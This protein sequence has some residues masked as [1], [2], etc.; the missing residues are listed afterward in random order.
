MKYEPPEPINL[1]YPEQRG[2][3]LV[4]RYFETSPVAYENWGP[5]GDAM[6]DLTQ[7]LMVRSAI[8]QIRLDLFADLCYADAGYTSPQ[9][10]F[11]SRGICGKAIFRHPDFYPHLQFFI[12]G[13][14]LPLLFIEG[15]CD[16][17]NDDE[18]ASEKYGD[19]IEKS[20]QRFSLDRNEIAPEL[21][22]LGIEIGMG[23]ECAK[24][25]RTAASATSD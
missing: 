3:H 25:L 23:I 22:R 16:M 18:R 17:L 2:Y 6:F 15:L 7:S 4:W 14:H 20:V 1:S 12:F 19:F 13:P 21:F 8:P 24:T 5:A 11:E 10:V 9:Q